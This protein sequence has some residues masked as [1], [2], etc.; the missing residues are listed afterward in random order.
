MKLISNAFQ[1]ETYIPRKYTC[2]GAN[3]NPPLSIQD[4]PPA[5]QSLVLLLEDPDVPKYIRE[6]HM[7][8]H[9][10]IFNISPDTTEIVEGEEPKG[11]HGIGTGGNINY[12]G[13]CPPQGEH[14]YYFKIFA[15]D[16]KLELPEKST[17]F[18]VL[19]HMKN[20]IL[21]KAELMGMYGRN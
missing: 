16:C 9:W 4:I 10:I 21:D 6:D 5:T 2:D 8:D 14:R 13:P 12:Y 11:T 18:H 1:S 20:H 17:K 19:E 3:T 15:L 7:W